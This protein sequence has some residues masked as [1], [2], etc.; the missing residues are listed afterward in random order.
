[1]WLSNMD[2]ANSTPILPNPAGAEWSTFN[3]EAKP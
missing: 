1:V 2:A 3:W